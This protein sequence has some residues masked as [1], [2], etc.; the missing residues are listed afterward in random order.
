MKD[1]TIL[2]VDDIEANRVSLQYLIQEYLENVHLILAS[3]G[4]EALKITY[5]EE[6]DIIILDVQMPGLDGFDTAKYLKSNPRTQNIPIIFLTAA[7]KKEEFQQKGFQIGAVD[8]LTKPIENHQFIN[9]LNLYIEVIIKNK[10]LK[11][12]NDNLYKALQKEIELKEQIQ[13]QQLELIEQSK[14]A[15]LGEM[16]GNIAHQWRQPLSLIS[17]CA[18]GIK[19]NHEL[20]ISKE[21]EVI[22]SLETILKTAQILSETIDNFREYSYKDKLAK[23]NLSEVIN[24]AIKTREH[25]I[26]ENSI[27]VITNL[28][29]N[30]E[31]TN[32]PN[33]LVQA[34]VNII[35][36]SKDALEKIDTKRYI[37]IES[38]ID[39]NNLIV[40]NI[41]DNAGGIKTEHINKVFEPYFT[42]KHQ[43]HGIGLGL[44]I[45]YK[46]I[47]DS[48]YGKIKIKNIKYTY[49][50]KIYEGAE[51]TIT[52]PFKI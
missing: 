42:T 50:E 43:A 30:I 49:Q 7:F 27:E 33:S 18:S 2:A 46:I 14:M 38:F 10:Q 44:N 37:F 24:K 19:L 11:A 4:E 16:I 3:S 47:N 34:L 28:D 45:T 25:L 51:V 29:N 39:K 12:V 8:Y 52:L 15:A 23:F 36:N 26:N 40:I 21:E 48:M 17:T 31:L 9:K 32:L 35:H 5:K 6:I 1:I 22:N 41:K 20:G 13:K